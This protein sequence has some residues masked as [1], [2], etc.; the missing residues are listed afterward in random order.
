MF[1][2]GQVMHV[3][4]HRAPFPCQVSTMLDKGEIN[5]LILAMSES[6]HSGPIRCRRRLNPGN[7]KISTTWSIRDDR[8]V[9]LEKYHRRSSRHHV[10]VRAAHRRRPTSREGCNNCCRFH[11]KFDKLCGEQVLALVKKWLRRNP[12]E[13]CTCTSSEAKSY[14]LRR[15]CN[16]T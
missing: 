16:A 4:A 15:N 6:C 13:L 9:C 8:D 12:E 14:N 10:F 2:S 3:Y 7:R 11:D 1:T 5:D